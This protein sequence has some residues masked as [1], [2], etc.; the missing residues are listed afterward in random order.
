LT[1]IDH[2]HF[3]EYF[4]HISVDHISGKLE[5]QLR[6]HK[7]H[8]RMGGTSILNSLMLWK[9]NQQHIKCHKRMGEKFNSALSVINAW[10]D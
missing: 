6:V 9:A 2:D 5:I 3:L 8:K 10:G 7:C 1:S 4:G